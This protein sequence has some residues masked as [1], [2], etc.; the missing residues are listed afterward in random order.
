MTYTRTFDGV[1]NMEVT[2]NKKRTSSNTSLAIL[3]KTKNRTVAQGKSLP[4]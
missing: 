4:V 3:D 2:Q 1:K